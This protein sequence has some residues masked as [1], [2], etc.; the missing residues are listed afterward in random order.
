MSGVRLSRRLF[1]QA[2]AFLLPMGA[3]RVLADA[4]KPLPVDHGI[5]GT[6]MPI[7]RRGGEDQGIGGTGVFGRI[8]KF[9]SIYV[10]DLRIH[11]PPD[12]VVFIDGRRAGVEAMRIGHVVRAALSGTASRPQTQRIDITSEVIGPIEQV[13]A[14]TM[15]VLSQRIDLRTAAYRPKLKP[16]MTV[17]V[18][19][20][21]AP[22]GQIVASRVETRPRSA[23]WIVRGVVERAGGRLRIGGLTIDRPAGALAGHR[24][25]A[26][27]AR[28]ARGLVLRRITEEILVPG[29]GSGRVIVETVRSSGE[30]GLRSGPSRGQP[31][32][33]GYF[34]LSIGPDGRAGPMQGM[35]GP[36]PGLGPGPGPNG[37]PYPGGHPPPGGPPPGRHPF[38]GGFFEGR[39]PPGPPGGRAPPGPPGGRG[40]PPG[41]R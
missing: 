6:G 37:G 16:G 17:A 8:R 21:R 26:E 27:I 41:R 10:N 18:F 31:M 3:S 34:N 35:P 30:G 40:P 32:E 33:P 9:G 28:A 7:R 38:E 15:T 22:D 20:I 4:P 11:Y 23:R 5:G 14:E 29:L 36:G 25:E 1:L 13:G 24:V 2:A 39:H 19:G 12:V